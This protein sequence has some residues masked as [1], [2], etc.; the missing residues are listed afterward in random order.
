MHIADY[1]YNVD[2]TMPQRRVVYTN[3]SSHDLGHSPAHLQLLDSFLH[4]CLRKSNLH[5][6]NAHSGATS[7]EDRRREIGPFGLLAG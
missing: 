1:T 3:I 6:R 7:H 2:V 5:S 4:A